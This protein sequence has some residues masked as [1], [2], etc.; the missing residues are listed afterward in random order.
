M[1]TIFIMLAISV[2]C[3]ALGPVVQAKGMVALGAHDDWLS[4]E[5]FRYFGRAL[6]TPTVIVGTLLHAV[7][8]FLNLALLA[9]AP[10]SF[11]VPLTAMEYIVGVML[12]RMIL[13]EIVEPMRWAGV[14][15]IAIGV[16]MMSMTWKPD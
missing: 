5:T 4:L 3:A 16:L 7:A 2:T 12:A 6:T 10:V 15:V 1:L 14:G 8:F 13:G 11:I 9:R